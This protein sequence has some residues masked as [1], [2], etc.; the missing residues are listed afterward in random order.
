MFQVRQPLF[1]LDEGAEDWSFF[2]TP[3]ETPADDD[4]PTEESE[5]ENLETDEQ[6][7]ET[8]EDE[9]SNEAEEG[10]EEEGEESPFND[11]TEVT[12][13]EGQTVKLKE[14]KDG[15]LR[16]SDYTKKTQA[17][18]EERKTFEAER[19]RLQPV[20][21]M[22]DFLGANPYLR[23]QIHGFIQ[24]FTTTGQI[25]L[26]EALQDAAYGQ[27]IN[28][29][30]AQNQ[31]LQQQLQEMQGKYGELEF[32]GTMKDLKSGLKAEYGDLATDEYL[33][34]LEDRAKA[35]RLPLN[36]LQEI[37]DAHLA[38]QKLEQVSK[39]TKK[40]VKDA[41]TQTYQ[42][43]REKSEN[44]LSQPRKK[45]QV[46]NSSKTVDPSEPLGWDDIFS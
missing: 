34:S 46:P 6:D 29:L 45:G 3:A 36:V 32:T 39:K 15:F 2:D 8:V 44:N 17:L 28:T 22:S 37:A 42:K 5:A 41:E 12:I 25:S 31:Q 10:K 19:E 4:Q 23:E 16:Q 38:K 33:K 21:Q 35:E 40:A 43:M 18:A 27:Y 26:Q 14:L 11:E 9:E 7:V 30:M 20:Q 13:G 24:E 1:R